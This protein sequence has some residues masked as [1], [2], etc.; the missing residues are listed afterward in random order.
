[1]SSLSIDK[2]L[3][4][5]VGICSCTSQGTDICLGCGRASREVI[6]WNSYSNEKKRSITTRIKGERNG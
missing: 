2:S 1:M 5:C 6:E 3:W 4:P